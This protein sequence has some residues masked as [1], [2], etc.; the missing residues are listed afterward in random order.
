[1]KQ[2]FD[3]ESWDRPDKEYVKTPS[4]RQPFRAIVKDL[5]TDQSPITAKMSKKILK[6]LRRIRKVGI[7]PMDV[8]AR[9]Y[10]GGLLVD[11][12]VAM[13][14]PH[15]LFLIK[16][17]WRVEEDYKRDDLIAFQSMMKD[18]GIETWERAVRNE[19][20]CKK[21]RSYDARNKSPK[22]I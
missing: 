18:E 2:S 16:E 1:M 8:Q 4:R 14:E 17:P 19:E 6:D 15:Y 22:K 9:N 3:I 5:I 20:Y 10:K 7:Y 13:T 21:F 12:S 11:F